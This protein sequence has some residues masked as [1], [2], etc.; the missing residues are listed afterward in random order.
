MQPLVGVTKIN[1]RVRV[2]SG[3]GSKPTSPA[4]CY[5]GVQQNGKDQV[6]GKLFSPP[7]LFA[8]S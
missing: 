2:L 3:R 6:Q 7:S 5:D 8:A 4:L 1:G